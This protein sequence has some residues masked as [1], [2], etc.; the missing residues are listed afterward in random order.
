MHKIK[1]KNYIEGFGYDEINCSNHCI[2]AVAGSFM[3]DYYR[4]GALLFACELIWG[5]STNIDE[6]G[7][8]FHN[9]ILCNFG[10]CIQTTTAENIKKY[11]NYI[12]DGL[13]SATPIILFLPS[14]YIPWNSMQYKIKSETVHSIV[15]SGYDEIRN[16]FYIRDNAIIDTSSLDNKNYV[17][18]NTMWE[19]CLPYEIVYSILKQAN[20]YLCNLHNYYGY[21]IFYMTT[22]GDSVINSNMELLN[23]IMKKYNIFHYN[24]LANYV[25]NPLLKINAPYLADKVTLT[26]NR[27]DFF[28]NYKLI[29]HVLESL[30]LDYGNLELMN[31]LYKLRKKYIN[32]KNI[33]YNLKTRSI[34]TDKPLNDIK[35]NKLIKQIYEDDLS[36][37]SF[38]KYI[39]DIILG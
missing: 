26:A 6:R 14:A 29:F 19:I 23:F 37:F 39:R 7:I 32:N 1:M 15:I 13:Y 22:R 20:E 12:I 28:G 16:L 35:K 18:T 8:F 34:I 33:I 5:K 17:S 2:L 4:W 10:L 11:M 36:L 3:D 27:L 38:I 25:N 31:K 9:D 24:R 30:C 21:R